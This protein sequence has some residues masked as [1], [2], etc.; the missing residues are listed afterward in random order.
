MN[1]HPEELVDLADQLRKI[2][3]SEFSY[4]S[5]GYSV[6]FFPGAGNIVAHQIEE[7]KEEKRTERDKS[8]PLPPDLAD[9]IE[10]GLLD[11]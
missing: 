6:R 1:H 4:G 7:P 10:E 8:I 3:V 2:G 9:L 5:Q 11:H